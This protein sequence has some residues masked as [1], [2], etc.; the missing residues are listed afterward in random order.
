MINDY[1]FEYDLSEDKVEEFIEES[2]NIKYFLFIYYLIANFLFFYY[3][4]RCQLKKSP[5]YLRTKW[6]VIFGNFG[7]QTMIIEDF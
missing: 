3:N 5:I 2:V 4:Y 1:E 6:K 7:R